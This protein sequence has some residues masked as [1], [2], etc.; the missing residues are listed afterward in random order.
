MGV[1]PRGTPSS[2]RPRW[3][4]LEVQ[5]LG[6]GRSE[7]GLRLHSALTLIDGFHASASRSQ[8]SKSLEPRTA[9]ARSQRVV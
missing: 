2:P 9:S 6:D 5:R 1:L 4:G 7:S 3:L 8:R